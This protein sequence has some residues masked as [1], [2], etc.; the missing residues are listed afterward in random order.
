MSPQ[1]RQDDTA[2]LALPGGRDNVQGLATAPVTLVEYG[3]YECL[4]CRAAVAVGA[5]MELGGS[6]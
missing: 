6:A 1:M 4:Y 3:N 2:R 5:G